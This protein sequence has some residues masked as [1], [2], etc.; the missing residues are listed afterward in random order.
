LRHTKPRGFDVELAPDARLCVRRC[1]DGEEKEVVCI[2]TDS[3]TTLYSTMAVA[4]TPQQAHAV[5]YHLL[6]EASVP[7]EVK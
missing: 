3:G 6:H 5:A 1:W 4:L 7:L 2:E